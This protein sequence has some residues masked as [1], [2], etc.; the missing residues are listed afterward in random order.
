M[1]STNYI[2]RNDYATAAPQDQFIVSLLKYH[3]QQAL[4]NYAKPTNSEARA[5]DVGC[6]SQPFRSDLEALHYS[7]T[8]LDAEQNSEDSVDIICLIDQPLLPE[9]LKDKQFDFILCTE[10]MEHVANWQG[11]FE[12]FS[13]LLAP[14]GRL[15]ITCPFIYPLHEE[16]YDYWRP[17]PYAFQY[18]ADKH[19]LKIIHQVN[20]GDAWDVLGTVLATFHTEPMSRS[21]THRIINKL[22][23]KGKDF[24]LNL[25]LEGQLQKALRAKGKLYQANIVVFEK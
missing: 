2:R 17:T 18:F 11:A 9:T 6:G 13:K 1:I 7:Y 25:L 3:I 19:D 22:V 12:N 24:L 23:S 16:P 14:G 20:A 8:S 4:S 15:L 21:L 10:V 5:L